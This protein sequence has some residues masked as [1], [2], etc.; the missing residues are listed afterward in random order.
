MSERILEMW[1][2][3]AKKEVV[4]KLFQGNAPIAIDS[5]SALQHYMRKEKGSFILQNQGKVFFDSIA[6]VFNA[7]PNAKIRA[8]TTREDFID[9]QQMVEYYNSSGQAKCQFTV[10]PG[11]VKTGVEAYLPDMDV[12]C[13]EVRQH[14][15]SAV[16]VLKKYDLEL[17]N[18]PRSKSEYARKSLQDF[19]KSIQKSIE[20][21]TQNM[22][23][24]KNNTVNLCFAGVYS[25]GKSAL[26]NAL[27]GYRILPENVESKTARM[28]Q[29]RSPRF[30]NGEKISL[31]FSIGTKPAELQWNEAAGQMVFGEDPPENRLVA[32]INVKAAEQK[33]APKHQQIYVLLE[34][35]NSAPEISSEIHIKFPIPLDT[36]EVQFSIYDTPGT[37]SN[38]TTHEAI[39]RK[40]L[41]GQT[42]SILVFVALP[43]KLEGTG[44][45]KLLSLVQAADTADHR[46][47]IDIS[48]S[49]FVINAADSIRPRERLQLK[50]SEISDTEDSSFTIKLSDQKLLFTSA[51]YAY[52]AK[53]FKNGIIPA[54]EKNDTF[55]D[56]YFFEEAVTKA[57]EGERG[58]YYKEDCCASS[59]SATAS[60]L[61]ACDDALRKAQEADDKAEIVHICSGL[62]A[63]EREILQYGKKYAAAVRA[64]AIINSVDSVLAEL[65]TTASSLSS[66]NTV[67]INKI[68][69]D[70]TRVRDELEET[71]EGVVDSFKIDEIPEYIAERLCLGEN[72]VR[73]RVS[74][75]RSFVAENYKGFFF[76]KPKDDDCIAIAEK[77]TQEMQ[78]ILSAY[79]QAMPILLFETRDAVINEIRNCVRSNGNLTEKAKEFVCNFVSA[80]VS[81]QIAPFNEVR[82]AY[83]ES[84]EK[85][86]FVLK[87]VNVE[88]LGDSLAAEMRESIDDIADKL[89]QQYKNNL[90]RTVNL[91]QQQF[92][93]RLDQYSALLKGM[94]ED[95]ESM[96]LLGGQIKEIESELQICQKRL[97]ESIWKEEKQ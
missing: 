80:E 17:I 67:E 81:L 51:R 57:N 65:N 93:D 96:E 40:A 60:L 29:I 97:N 52:V 10:L 41:G 45:R 25:A 11:A 88:R 12:I 20:N 50:D 94:V 42:S 13:G 54:D 89:R 84:I 74:A 2:H 44:N 69:A 71:I 33:G 15:A 59:E 3:P 37:D 56:A 35:L 6:K 49:L 77:M 27:L 61:N 36:P 7:V 86:L 8:I 63:L 55:D 34:M 21:I 28:F 23:R 66:R 1:Y 87:R 39:L 53:A 79:S 30:E 47:P 76:H 78:T 95:R 16:D 73:D 85:R 82:Q 68:N 92:T 43:K 19:R 18:F 83:Q 58:K 48:R 72:C 31:S 5:R 24:L 70:I 64:Y 91:V 9:F 75:V 4:F 26:I 38:F 62:Y 14:G 46:S 22:D 90:T 32:E